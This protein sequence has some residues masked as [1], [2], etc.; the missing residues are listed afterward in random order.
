MQQYCKDY[1]LEYLEEIL[2]NSANTIFISASFGV[3]VSKFSYVITQVTC[4]Q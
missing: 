2:I 1:G 4:C 3:T